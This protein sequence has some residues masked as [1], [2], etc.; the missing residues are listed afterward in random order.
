MLPGTTGCGKSFGVIDTN[1]AGDTPGCG[2]GAPTVFCCTWLMTCW[3]LSA[4]RSSFHR[5]G[6]GGGSS[7]SMLIGTCRVC[8]AE[9][10]HGNSK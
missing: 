7:T 4:T 10:D 1:G 8:D 2:F 3:R 5:G 9:A 6:G